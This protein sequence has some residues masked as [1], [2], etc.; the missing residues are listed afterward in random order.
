[1]RLRRVGVG[2]VVPLGRQRNT[3][4]NEATAAPSETQVPP[5]TR[6]LRPA[7]RRK[8]REMQLLLGARASPVARW[9]RAGGSAPRYGVALATPAPPSWQV[10]SSTVGE[11]LE[12]GMENPPLRNPSPTN[13]PFHEQSPASAECRCLHLASYGC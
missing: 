9:R 10:R 2:L 13:F 4:N 6:R 3:G 12:F 5:V 8:N 7:V 1:V 11:W